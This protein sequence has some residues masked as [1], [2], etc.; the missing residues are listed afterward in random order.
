M[1]VIGRLDGQVE[2]VIINP[3]SRRPR[4]DE[5]TP[6]PPPPSDDTTSR[7]PPANESSADSDELPVWLL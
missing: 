4:G 7:T 5:E 2:E 1:P 6:A 3:V